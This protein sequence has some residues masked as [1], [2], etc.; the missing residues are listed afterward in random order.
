[1]QMW[2]CGKIFFASIVVSFFMPMIVTQRSS[3]CQ[4][5]VGC[6]ILLDACFFGPVEYMSSLIERWSSFH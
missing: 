6:S 4:L 2:F 5:S 3:S 1:M